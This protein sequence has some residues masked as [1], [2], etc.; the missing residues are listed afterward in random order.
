MTVM[1]RV[2]KSQYSW[3]LVWAIGALLLLVQ[4]CAPNF[5]NPNL[6]L[7]TESHA[8]EVGAPIL[9][10][11]DIRMRADPSSWDSLGMA[12]LRDNLV[13]ALQNSSAFAEVLPHVPPFRDD[14]WTLNVDLTPEFD[15]HFASPWYLGMATMLIAWPIMPRY[16]IIGMVLDATLF[17]HGQVL[18]Q[19]HLEERDSMDL[20]IFGPYR[21]GAVQEQTDQLMREALSHLGDVLAEKGGFHSYAQVAQ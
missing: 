9:A 14:V 15:Q 2:C 1:V 6:H 13:I 11:D 18:Q 19:I 20:F 8:G 5:A 12:V 7:Q 4:G 3:I 17:Q 16:G 10:L 21:Q